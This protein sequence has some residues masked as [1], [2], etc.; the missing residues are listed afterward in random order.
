MLSA[1]FLVLYGDG[2][3]HQTHIYELDPQSGMIIAKNELKTI[4]K[5]S[6]PGKPSHDFYYLYQL[7]RKIQLDDFIFNGESEIVKKKLSELKT[8][9]LPFTISLSELSKIRISR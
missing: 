8:A 7:K 1:K 5:T 2:G 6:Y 9:S 4:G 3:F